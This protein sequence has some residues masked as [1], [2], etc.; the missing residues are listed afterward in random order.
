MLKVLIHLI[1][2]L[3]Q[4]GNLHLTRGN[5]TLKLLNL[6]VKHELELFQLLCLFLQLVNLLLSIPNQLVFRTYLICLVLDFSLQASKDLLLVG[7]LDVLLLL[8]A[9]ELLDVRL[10]VLVLVLRQLKLS[11]GLQTHVLHLRLVL[12]VLLVDLVNLELGIC[13]DLGKGFLIV[14]F[15]LTDVIL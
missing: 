3:L 9:L 12:H 6:I 7:H 11:F 2:F 8:V 14:R 1:G 4:A 13:F 10:E 5:I 15:D